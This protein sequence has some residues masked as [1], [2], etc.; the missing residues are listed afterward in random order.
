MPAVGARLAAFLGPLTDSHKSALLLFEHFRLVEQ[1][2]EAFVS[3]R[4]RRAVL[5]SFAIRVH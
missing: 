5:Q 4:E 1:K 3:T 2:N